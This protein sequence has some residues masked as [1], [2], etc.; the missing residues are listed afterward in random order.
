MPKSI[1]CD[2]G[3]RHSIHTFEIISLEMMLFTIICGRSPIIVD[4]LI[5]EA[6]SIAEQEV[7][8]NGVEMLDAKHL[9]LIAMQMDKRNR[10]FRSEVHVKLIEREASA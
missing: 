5:F 6:A 2:S 9:I 4:I 10:F 1:K 7:F 8:Y 3:D